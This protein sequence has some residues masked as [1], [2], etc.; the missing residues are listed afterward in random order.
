MRNIVVREHE[1][2]RFG[3]IDPGLKQRL[4]KRLERFDTRDYD[5]PVFFWGNG[6]LKARQWIG[7]VQVP[8]LQVE[9][10]PKITGLGDDEPGRNGARANLLYM[11]QVAGELRFRDR[12]TA[13]FLGIGVP[14]LDVV[15][16]MFAA[17]LWRE[18][19]RG[20][21][22]GY[23]HREGNLLRFKG[24]LLI[25]E[26]LRH[27]AAHR[28]RFFCHFDEFL[29]D[30][31]INRVFKAACRRLL[32]VT[33]RPA[34]QESLRQCLLLLDDVQ[35]LPI[36]PT[37]FEE[38]VFTRQNRR[39]EDLFRF[40]RW[41]IENQS[42]S[43]RAGKQQSFSMLFNMNTVFEKFIA[44][45]LRRRVG[46]DLGCTIRAQSKGRA[47][48]LMRPH[49]GGRGGVL[50]RPDV[51]VERARLGSESVLVIDTKWKDLGEKSRPRNPDM[52]QLY[53]YL[54][55][56][57][58]ERGILLYPKTTDRQEPVFDV[59]E[60]GGETSGE[61]CVRFV[62]LSRDFRKKKERDNLA[63]ELR[64]MVSG[65]LRDAEVNV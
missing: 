5:D 24:K 54:R 32:N 35:D 3:D 37:V 45:F 58:G 11:L 30:T 8:G 2:L 20:L 62:N 39:F 63:S 40:C 59:L 50:L 44:E 26:H 38:M 10:L 57:G 60:Q 9:I 18:L 27:N 15:V 6:F 1:R 52:Y 64:E 25:T 28:E 29:P 34:T 48:W 49:G 12:A 16:R 17:H 65:G 7:V 43:M 33:Q 41:V 47:E 55:R 22:S 23:V 4:F 61:V 13:G 51:L 36:L 42:P 14:L 53:A 31:K 46:T 19:L 21:D 56:F